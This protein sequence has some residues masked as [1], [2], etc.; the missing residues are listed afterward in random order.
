MTAMGCGLSRKQNLKKK[1]SSET[2]GLILKNLVGMINGLS[3]IEVAKMNLIHQNTWPPVGVA[4]VLY[5]VCMILKIS[6]ETS[7]QN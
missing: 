3:S 1:I 2:S 6:S 4:S 5:I 7:G